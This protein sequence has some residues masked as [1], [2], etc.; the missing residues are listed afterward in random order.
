MQ[1][2]SEHKESE[3]TLSNSSPRMVKNSSSS[4]ALRLFAFQI[5]SATSPTTG[6]MPTLA[7]IALLN[8]IRRRSHGGSLRKMTTW[9]KIRTNKRWRGSN[10]RQWSPQTRK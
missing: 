1:R 4:Q 6:T 2:A 8:N 7:L 3:H 5:A 10:R 9:D